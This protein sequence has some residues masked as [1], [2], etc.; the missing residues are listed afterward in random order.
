MRSLAKAAMAT[1]CGASQRQP[2][3]QH[4]KAAMATA[5]GASQR[6]PWP[7][8]AE[9]RKGSHYAENSLDTHKVTKT[10][11]TFYYKTS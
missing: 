9:P 5:C 1:A 4:A 11:N 7:Q 8:H 10:S 6:Q 3:P 2:W